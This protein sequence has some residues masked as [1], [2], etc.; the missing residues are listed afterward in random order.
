MN[1][2]HPSQQKSILCLFRGM[3]SP[4][5]LGGNLNFQSIVVSPSKGIL[6]FKT[7]TSRPAKYEVM[8]TRR[9]NFASGS[10]GEIVNGTALISTPWFK[11]LWILAIEQQGIQSHA[12]LHRKPCPSPT[13]YCYLADTITESSKSYSTILWRLLTQDDRNH[14]EN[15]GKTSLSLGHCH[16]SFFVNWVPR[17]EAMLGGMTVDKAFCKSMDGILTERL[18]TEKG[19]SQPVSLFQ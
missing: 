10:L 2:N 8:R 5:C 13:S 4:K 17:S 6:P 15:S 19:N 11:D 14:G 3:K 9:K 12:E 18:H 16:T 7:K 1:I